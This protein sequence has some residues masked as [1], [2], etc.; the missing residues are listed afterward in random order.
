MAD[1]TRNGGAEIVNLLKTSAWYAPA[2][3]VVEMVDAV[4]KDK[5]KILPCA[6]FLQGEYGMKDVYLGVPVKLGAK[7]MEQV[8]EF[9]LDAVSFAG[10]FGRHQTVPSKS[11]RIR[12]PSR[13]TRARMNRTSA[14]NRP[15][16]G[17]STWMSTSL[18]TC[19]TQ[20]LSADMGMAITCTAMLIQAMALRRLALTGTNGAQSALVGVPSGAFLIPGAGPVGGITGS[21]G[22]NEPIPVL[23]IEASAAAGL[24]AAS[25]ATVPSGRAVV[26]IRDRVRVGSDLVRGLALRKWGGFEADWIDDLAPQGFAPPTL[27]R[28][29]PSRKAT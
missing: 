8:V 21:G 4:L 1:R 12:V 15:D 23:T 27:Q 28:F 6:A 2:S 3:A 19:C 17:T 20:S 26:S 13:K 10:R 9:D 25:Q 18:V 7:G 5:K 16:T 14:R 24:P 29:S 11:S 22:G